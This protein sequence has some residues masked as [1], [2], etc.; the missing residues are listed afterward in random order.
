MDC[1]RGIVD[2][3]YMDVS[4]KV[5]ANRGDTGEEEASLRLI[6]GFYARC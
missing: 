5:R 2:K 3:P 6:G 1:D 4:F